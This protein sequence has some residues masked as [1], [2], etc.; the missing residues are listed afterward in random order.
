MRNDS[1]H[2]LRYQ[3]IQ[4]YNFLNSWLNFRHLNLNNLD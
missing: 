2:K 3:K 1:K 4:A